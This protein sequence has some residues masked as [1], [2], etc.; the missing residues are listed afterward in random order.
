MPNWCSNH[1]EL[2]GPRDKIEQVFGKAKEENKLLELL[3]P[4]P[5]G[6][7]DRDFAINH[8]GTKWDVD[9]EGLDFEPDGAYSRISGYIDSA[10]SPPTEA[11]HTWLDD[12]PDCEAQ[13]L[14]YE[15]AMDFAGSMDG[16]ITISE[17][18]DEYFKKT[19]LGELLDS[20]FGILDDRLEE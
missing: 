12:N 8:W 20:H 4:F 2:V 18:D 19:E 3:V 6:E 15:P 7:Y 9:I 11:L 17:C 5:D 16:E 13:L 1:I 14:Y 10:W